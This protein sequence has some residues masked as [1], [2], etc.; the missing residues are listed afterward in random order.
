MG[1]KKTRE[2]DFKNQVGRVKNALSGSY[3]YVP[4]TVLRPEPIEKRFP[5]NALVMAIHKGEIG[6]FEIEVLDWVSK[7][8]Y[9]T[10]AMIMDLII[11]GYISLGKREKISADKMSV[12][13]DR[14][15]K[16]S[17]IDLTRMVSVTDEG[18]A[19]DEK[20][21]SIMRV[22][23]IG[24][25]GYHLLKEIGRSP[26]R[27]DEFTVLADGNTVKK[28][29]SSNQWIIYWLTHFTKEQIV[30]YSI[31]QMVHLFGTEWNAARIYATVNMEKK[32]MIAEPVKRCAD[33]EV[34]M[35]NEWMR[36]KYLRFV[37][38]FDNLD[39]LYAGT[40]EPVVYTSRPVITY[41]CEDDDHINEVILNLRTLMDEHPQQEVWFTTDQRT[42]NY[43]MKGKRFLKLEENQLVAVNLMEELGVEEISMEERGG[44]L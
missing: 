30:D 23:T 22:N 26:Q 27:R 8:K 42:F 25:T 32:A 10:K 17:L 37:E 44:L 36:G 33:F 9:S 13:F 12:I 24:K 31:V 1:N 4:Q 15:C 28:C 34:E 40:R 29:L 18:N 39:K 2:Q 35:E 19:I 20:R 6:S 38:L 14:L 5:T 21:R 3:M 7:L 11:S 16:Y 41:L 43:N